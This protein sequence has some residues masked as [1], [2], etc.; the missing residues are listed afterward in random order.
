VINI[1]MC[2]FLCN[3]CICLL[4]VYYAWYKHWNF[5][6]ICEVVYFIVIMERL[7][8]VSLCCSCAFTFVDTI[9]CEGLVQ[10]KSI[11]HDLQ[12]ENRCKMQDEK[13]KAMMEFRQKL[14]SYRMKQ[15][16]SC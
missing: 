4:F 1:L 12:Q 5:F 13:F 7:G 8:F 15:V 6:V 2:F 9:H 3:V 11:D 14:P 10:D 16:K